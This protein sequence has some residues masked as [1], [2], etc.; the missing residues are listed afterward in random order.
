AWVIDVVQDSNFPRAKAAAENGLHDAFGFP[1]LLEDAVIG[2]VEFFSR[3]FREPDEALLEMTAA[4]GSQIGQFVERKRAEEELKQA[5]EPAE[6][7]AKSKSEFLAIMSHEIRTPMNAVIGM[8]GL[9]LETEL[10]PVQ[11]DYAETIRVSGESL[12]AVI[13]DILD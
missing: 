3:Q 2:V 6:L 4:L 9:M 5:K 11:R 1:I 7:A 8:T 10:S 12:L 13:N